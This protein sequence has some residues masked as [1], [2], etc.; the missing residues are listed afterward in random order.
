MTILIVDNDVL[1]ADSIAFIFRR[2][3]YDV[4]HAPNGTSGL[5]HYQKDDP[6]LILVDV[7]LPDMNGLTFCRSIRIESHIPLILLNIQCREEDIIHGLEIGADDYIIK[8]FSPRQL[9]A[10]TKA[11]LRRARYG[12]NRMMHEVGKLTFD[13]MRRELCLESGEKI[14]LSPLESR[15]LDYFLI[16]MGQVLPFEAIIAHLWGP[17]GG[18]HSMVRQLVYRVRN[19]VE[20]Y[21][22][23]SVQIRSVVG[24][25]YELHTE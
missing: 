13:S 8:P 10:R 6:A 4:V 21:S 19:K 9:L 16:N 7:N 1:L 22:C 5:R 23:N 3:K 12:V 14:R 20:T 24:I 11:L 17:E 15:L 25:G 18:T 2:E